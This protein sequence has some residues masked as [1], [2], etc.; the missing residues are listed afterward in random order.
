M[1]IMK[2]KFKLQD[3]DCANCAAKMEEGIKKIDGVQDASVSFMTQKMTIEADEE[4]F[5][6][7]MDEVVKVCAKIEPDCVILR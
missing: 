2:K 6:E 4:G 7:L 1:K 3:L 5:E